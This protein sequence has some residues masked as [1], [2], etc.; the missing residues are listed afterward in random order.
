M[1]LE[2]YLILEV[3]NLSFFSLKVRM[4]ENGIKKAKQRT[5][6]PDANPIT[7]QVIQQHC[8]AVFHFGS[9]YLSLSM[10]PV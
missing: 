5:G 3:T 4:R 7:P 8:L 6:Q 1:I 2:F 9:Q 10:S